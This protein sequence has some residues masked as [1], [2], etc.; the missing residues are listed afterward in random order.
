MSVDS[1][2]QKKTTQQL[3]TSC[4]Q[5]NKQKQTDTLLGSE[6]AQ[7]TMEEPELGFQLVDFCTSGVL[8]LV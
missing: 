4:Q 3:K 1:F 6:N 5:T 2:S 7:T 8:S